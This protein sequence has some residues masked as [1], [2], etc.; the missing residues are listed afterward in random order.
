MS[1]ESSTESLTVVEHP[2]QAVFFDESDLPIRRDIVRF[3]ESYDASHYTGKILT[4]DE[5]FC[6]KVCELVLIGV[7][8]RGIARR[9]RIARR[10]IKAIVG[11]FE[12]RGK[13]APLKKRLSEKM[14]DL[15]ELGLDVLC[16]KLERG[17]VPANVLPIVI[18][19]LSDKKALID[20][21]PTARLDVEITHEV[22][23]AAARD[24]LAL[25]KR[26]KAEAIEV[27]TG[28][29]VGT[30]DMES[31]AFSHVSS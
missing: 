28:R 16:E 12:S 18:G 4:K 10:S 27:G 21:D 5:E 31:E 14:G 20:G 17:E 15:I 30:S 24:Y 6:A 8:D 19:V 29:E 26:A 9:M 3:A 11:V 1:T 22:T 2:T 23:P 13:L 7:S 25:L